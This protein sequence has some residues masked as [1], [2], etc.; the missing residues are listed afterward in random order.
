MIPID[1]FLSETGDLIYER[2]TEYFKT[3]DS[4]Y[5]ILMLIPS[6]TDPKNVHGHHVENTPDAKTLVHWL[7]ATANDIESG[8]YIPLT[9]GK[10]N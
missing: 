2:L 8:R 9:T 6:P 5:C 1:E 4:M 3:P 7:R 10:M